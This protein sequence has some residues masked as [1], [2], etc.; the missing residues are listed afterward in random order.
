MIAI[1]AFNSFNVYSTTIQNIQT[2]K[3][4]V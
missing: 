4:Q 3:L 2:S 1:H